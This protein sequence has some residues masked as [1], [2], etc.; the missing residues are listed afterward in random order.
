MG[1][2]PSTPQAGSTTGPASPA[3]YDHPESTVETGGLHFI[4]FHGAT[5]WG[6]ILMLGLILATA[7]ALGFCWR[8]CR[9][10]W[11]DRSHYHQNP[12][13]TYLFQTMQNLQAQQHY[14]TLERRTRTPPPSP[15]YTRQGGAPSGHARS[16]AAA[17]QAQRAD[18][19]PNAAASTGAEYIKACLLAIQEQDDARH[20]EQQERALS[21][22]ASL[23]A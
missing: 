2:S 14:P 4:E 20:R 12:D 18:P 1:Q 6:T 7:A 13:Y 17:Q 3:V 5:A 8:R 19:P 23:L 9:R 10:R 22:T 15:C 21:N 11:G 16:P